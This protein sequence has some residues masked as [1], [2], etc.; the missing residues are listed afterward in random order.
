MTS[1]R[2]NSR[3]SFLGQSAAGAAALWAAPAFLR[4]AGANER[5]NL[6]FIGVGGRGGSNLNDIARNGQE[7]VVAICDVNENALNAAAQKYPNARKYVDFRKLFDDSNDIDAVVVSTCEHTHAY[8]TLP[9]LELGKHVYCEKPLTHN[10]VEARMVRLAAEKTKLVTQMGTQ[11]H[12]QDNFR[13]VAELIRSGVIGGVTDIH[14]WVSRSWGLQSPEDAKRFGDIVY[15]ADRPAEAQTPPAT[16]K[17]DLWLGPAPERP[18]NEV[19]FPGPKWYRWWDF[20]NG[21]MS[22]LGSHWVDYPYFACEL[23]APKTVE[24]LHDAPPHPEIAPA[25]LKVVYEY[26]P[27]GDKPACKLTWYQGEPKPALWT[28]GKIPQW[29]NGI[30]FVGDKGMLISD[31]TQHKLLPE[32]Q[33]DGA[34]LP[35]PFLPRVGG[36]HHQEWVTAIKTGSPTGSPFSYAGMLTEANHLGNV[37]FRAGQKIEW[38]SANLKI[39]NAPDAERFLSREPR[40]GWAKIGV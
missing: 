6:A 28:D 33:F 31:Y 21:T 22:D 24:A 19:Y 17:W 37:A 26:G 16:L 3:R 4:A 18:Y 25:S 30:L 7:N 15:V 27:R 10:V 39:P 29:G 14:V 34:K 12:A 36:Q 23:D 32:E 11:M 2:R 1:S 40:S 9:A 38:D 35:E 8:A 20:G 5:L 13:R